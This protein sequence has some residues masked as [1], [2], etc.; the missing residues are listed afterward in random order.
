[1]E[2][3]ARVNGE[4]ATHELEDKN[5]MVKEV[6]NQFSPGLRMSY[7]KRAAEDSKPTGAHTSH[8]HKNRSI[9]LYKNCAWRLHSDE[10]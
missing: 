3:Q 5:V 9:S 6:Q 1:M 7:Q 4:N 10:V 2:K 8:I